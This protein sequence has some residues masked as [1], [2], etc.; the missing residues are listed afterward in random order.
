MESFVTLVLS[1]PVISICRCGDVCDCGWL[2]DTVLERW[3]H[4]D[5]CVANWQIT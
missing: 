3:V 4:E 5:S 2:W 1:P